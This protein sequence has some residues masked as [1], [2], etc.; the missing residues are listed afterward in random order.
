MA[1]DNGTEPRAT[2]ELLAWSAPH[3][4]TWAGKEASGSGSRDQLDQDAKHGLS[5]LERKVSTDV[6]IFRV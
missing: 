2:P 5:R 4:E 6:E 1:A 3:L